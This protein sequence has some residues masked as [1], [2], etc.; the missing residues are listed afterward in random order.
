MTQQP[1]PT[2]KPKQEEKK[3]IPDV[4]PEIEFLK[5]HAWKNCRREKRE[6]RKWQNKNF[7]TITE[8]EMT[9]EKGQV[10]IGFKNR[11]TLKYFQKLIRRQEVV[12]NVSKFWMFY[13]L[14]TPAD[15]FKHR[16]IRD[17]VSRYQEIHKTETM[18]SLS[19][20]KR[21][22]STFCLLRHVWN[23]MRN[24]EPYIKYETDTLECILN[25]RKMSI[26]DHALGEL[27]HQV[28]DYIRHNG[29]NLNGRE[30][31]DVYHRAESQYIASWKI[32]CPERELP[33]KTF[34]HD[35]LP[36]NLK[37]QH[38]GIGRKIYKPK[39]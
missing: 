34:K 7:L 10:A 1:K 25:R 30:R 26:M 22:K 27:R 9:G 17:I 11:M 12:L 8:W 29:K 6:M 14:M 36:L 32:V 38:L 35:R 21:G 3:D 20:D 16:T 5:V 33:Q 37:Y 31:S 39:N 15:S 18:L 24:I 23:Y 13:F 4:K 19:G 28:S 2:P